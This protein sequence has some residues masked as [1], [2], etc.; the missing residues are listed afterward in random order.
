[1][2]G[3]YLWQSFVIYVIFFK[4]CCTLDQIHGPT[5]TDKFRN[6]R[7]QTMLANGQQLHLR[8]SQGQGLFFT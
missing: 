4:L 3:L 2:K 7:S 1:M 8:A 6:K 5:P